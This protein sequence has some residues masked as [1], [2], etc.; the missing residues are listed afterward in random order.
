MTA[1][2]EEKQMLEEAGLSA[3]VDGGSGEIIQED[4]NEENRGSR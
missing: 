2:A 1:L 3:D 4:D